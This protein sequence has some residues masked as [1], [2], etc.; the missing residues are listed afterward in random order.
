MLNE[1]QMEAGS[2]TTA[3]M[4]LSFLMAMAKHPE[5]LKRC[6][7]EVDSVCGLNRSPGIQ[8]D[9]PYLRAVMNEVSICVRENL[10]ES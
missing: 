7:N 8:D 2:D 3:S 10:Y 1:T 5:V 6:Q 9:L 4:L